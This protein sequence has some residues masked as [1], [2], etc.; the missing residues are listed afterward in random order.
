MEIRTPIRFSMICGQDIGKLAN[1]EDEMEDGARHWHREALAEMPRSHSGHKLKITLRLKT[2]I[3]TLSHPHLRR[4]ILML[5]LKEILSHQTNLLKAN[6]PDTP[7]HRSW[8][9]HPHTSVPHG[10]TPLVW[11][12]RPEA[13]PFSEFQQPAFWISRRVEEHLLCACKTEA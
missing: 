5:R 12:T 9:C 7:W 3:H 13:T 4:Q 6:A 2:H 10:H 1:R 8:T 11:S